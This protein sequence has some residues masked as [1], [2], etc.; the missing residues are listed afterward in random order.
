MQIY[1]TVAVTGQWQS[2]SQ[3]S[4]HSLGESVTQSLCQFVSLPVCQ[5]VALSVWGPKKRAKLAKVATANRQTASNFLHPGVNWFIYKRILS[6][7]VTKHS[8]HIPA[9]RT[10]DS[11]QST[12][13]SAL[14]PPLPP[15]R[16]KYKSAKMFGKLVAPHW[17]TQAKIKQLSKQ[18]WELKS[19][20]N[21]GDFVGL[22]L[23]FKNMQE[24]K[25]QKEYKYLYLNKFLLLFFYTLDLRPL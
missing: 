10:K 18:C 11:A 14:R 20:W 8:F 3:S 25:L 16:L 2:Q 24:G 17:A 9:R 15:Q 22:F 6:L 1:S 5:F 21:W 7:P 13:H 19:C 4:A 12:E 23:F